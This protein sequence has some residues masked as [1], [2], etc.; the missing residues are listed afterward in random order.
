MVAFLV[1][2]GILGLCVWVYGQ[3]GG[4]QEGREGNATAVTLVVF[5]LALCVAV[6]LFSQ[7]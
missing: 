4:G 3:S 7:K 6:A 5:V 1:I 2:G